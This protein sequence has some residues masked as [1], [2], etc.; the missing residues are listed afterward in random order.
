MMKKGTLF[1]ILEWWEKL[2][3]RHAK[4]IVVNAKGIRRRLVED[5]KVLEE[6]IEFLPNGADLEIFNPEDEGKKIE[7]EFELKN[8]FVVFFVGLIGLAQNPQIMIETAKILKG[9]QDI[10]FLIVGNGPVRE[11]CLD[12]IEKYNLK[13]VIMTGS[14]PRKEVPE[15]T[16]RAD[17][18]LA[19][20]KKDKLFT[21][22]IPSKIF[23]YMAG[24]R[25]IVINSEGEGARIVKE[26][27]CGLKAEIT[28]SEDLAEKIL[29]IYNN[30]EKGKK[31]GRNGWVYAKENFSKKE[32]AGELRQILQ[33]VASIKK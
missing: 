18:C 27:N 22:V 2:F 28:N 24:G 32:I 15:F 5:K 29:E 16:A 12:L 26:A 8:K 13:N 30:P 11:E 33:F 6:K 4:K 19:T 14:R 3:Y 17:V 21:E 9:K 25:P 23:D 31:L 7:K 20:H 10:R 1:K